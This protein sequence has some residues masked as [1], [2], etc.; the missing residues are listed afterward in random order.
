M[1]FTRPETQVCYGPEADIGTRKI[2]LLDAKLE[3]GVCLC[4]KTVVVRV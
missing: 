2:G 1:P 4:R 3:L